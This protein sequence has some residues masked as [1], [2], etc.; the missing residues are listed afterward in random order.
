MARKM[1]L[2]LSFKAD[3]KDL[4][5]LGVEN[6]TMEM[7]DWL[8]D[9]DDSRHYK[10]SRAI[11]QKEE[12]IK[13]FNDEFGTNFPLDGDEIYSIVEEWFYRDTWGEWVRAE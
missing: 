2:V 11:K 5:E 1:Y 4:K 13:E 8:Y 7:C 9:V 12:W 10:E 3:E 6:P